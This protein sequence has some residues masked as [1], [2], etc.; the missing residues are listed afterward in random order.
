MELNPY[1]V[2]KFAEFFT[3]RRPKTDKLAAMTIASVLGSPNLPTNS[4]RYYHIIFLLL[5]HWLI[6]MFMTSIFKFSNVYTPLLIFPLS[7]KISMYNIFSNMLRFWSNIITMFLSYS[8][9]YSYKSMN[10]LFVIRDVIW[11]IYK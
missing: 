9:L 10:I 3:L 2:K 7:F 4:T 5:N 11:F 8:A 6:N 1:L